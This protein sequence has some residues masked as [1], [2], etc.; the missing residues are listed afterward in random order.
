MRKSTLLLFALL[1]FL[2]GGAQT[3]TRVN[4][5]VNG[6]KIDISYSLS[7]A[8]NQYFNVS[9]YVTLDGG[10]TYKGPLKLVTGDVGPNILPGNKKI[11]W[12]ALK[13]LD[14]KDKPISFEIKAQYKAIKQPKVKNVKDRVYFEPYK[15]MGY[16]YISS[17][18]LGY[19][20]GFLIDRTF[21]WSI[22]TG[23]NFGY[24]YA[25]WLNDDIEY[26][27]LIGNSSYY[28]TGNNRESIA[29]IAIGRT[30]NIGRSV[31]FDM[32]VGGA[33]RNSTREIESDYSTLADVR[34]VDNSGFKVYMEAGLKFR[35]YK[36]YI[37]GKATHLIG[38]TTMGKYQGLTNIG[39][40]LGYI[41]VS[42]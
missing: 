42:Y 33:Y 19:S 7:G 29:A 22:R 28:Y 40:S 8:S 1:L 34:I 26:I 27:P 36:F 5:V 32:G 11:V 15:F 17:A 16:E 24:E 31:F 21:Y 38:K 6:E 9:L 35:I 3:V 39:L 2:L 4:A 13:E 30:F 41:F 18:P 10:V 25:T 20:S 23:F 12:D 37:G 14:I